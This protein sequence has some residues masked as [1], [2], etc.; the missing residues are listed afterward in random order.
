M[1]DYSKV[2]KKLKVPEAKAKDIMSR[3]IKHGSKV[4]L[5]KKK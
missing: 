4:Q 5:T 3:A 1:S 2:A